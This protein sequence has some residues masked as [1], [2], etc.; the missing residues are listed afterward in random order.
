MRPRSSLRHLLLPLPPLGLAL[1]CVSAD[2]AS[3]EAAPIA[4]RPFTAEEIR[5]NNPPGTELLFR[6]EE[7]NEPTKMRVVRFVSDDGE[8]AFLETTTIDEAG[9]QSGL[10]ETSS[11]AWTE[12]RDHATFSAELTTMSE[13]TVDVRGG[14]FEVWLYTVEDVDRTEG[15][16][17]I[18]RYYFAPS[19]PGP[20]VLLEVERDGGVAYRME[21]VERRTTPETGEEN[22]GP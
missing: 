11:H 2:S 14:S 17:Y 18:T 9:Q 7:L 21:L 16:P 10:P 4:P 8:R 20:P 22:A 3:P 12:L 5:Q 13:T 6:I 1:G 19:A 15:F